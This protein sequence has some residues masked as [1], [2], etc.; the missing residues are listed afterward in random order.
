MSTPSPVA[1]DTTAPPARRSL[2]R[3]AVRPLRAALG[4]LTL[5][6]TLSLA[7]SAHAQSLE[8]CGT[9]NVRLPLGPTTADLYTAKEQI[10]LYL[11]SLQQSDFTFTNQTPPLFENPFDL[12]KMDPYETAPVNGMP[13]STWIPPSLPD[14]IPTLDLEEL[15]RFWMYQTENDD[16]GIYM[17]TI[18]PEQFTLS[19]MQD[20]TRCRAVAPGVGWSTMNFWLPSWQYPGNPY[21]TDPTSRDAL[22]RRG[23]AWLALQMIMI[24]WNA[25]GGYTAAPS[26]QV[27]S[28]F[29]LSQ[30]TFAHPLP[31][32]TPP[33]P[34]DSGLNTGYELGGELSHMAFVYQ[35]VKDIIPDWVLP[36]YEAMLRMFAERVVFWGPTCTMANLATRGVH[37]LHLVWQLTNDADVWT[38]YDHLID[39]FYA[40][41]SGGFF[42]AGYFVD[43]GRFDSGYNETNLLQTVRLLQLDSNV[44]PEVVDVANR[45]FDLHAHLVFR[46]PGP[47]NWYSPNEFNTRA[48][49]AAVAGGTSRASHGGG[50]QRELPGVMAGLPWSHAFLRDAPILGPEWSDPYGPSLSPHQGDY[51]KELICRM[52]DKAYW[53]NHAIQNPPSWYAPLV[54]MDWPEGADRDYTQPQFATVQYQHSQLETW[55]DEVAGDPALALFPFE[56]QGPYLRSFDRELLYARFGGAPSD[57]GYVAL[58]HAGPVGSGFGTSAAGDRL[59][60]GFG[61]GQVATFWGPHTGAATRGMRFGHNNLTADSWSDWRTWPLHTVWLVGPSGLPTTAAAIANPNYDTTLSTQDFSTA[62]IAYAVSMEPCPNTIMQLFSFPLGMG[63]SVEDDAVAAVVRVCGDIP[64][65]L[66]HLSDLED[67]TL[68]DAVHYERAIYTGADGVWVQTTLAPTSNV[69]PITE[70]WETIP[71]FDLQQSWNNNWPYAPMTVRFTVWPGGDEYSAQTTLLQPG[72]LAMAPVAD[73]KKVY[74]ERAN[75]AYEIVFEDVQSVG[76]SAEWPTPDASVHARNLLIDRLGQGGLQTAPLRY[77]IVMLTDESGTTIPPPP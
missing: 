53:L 70:A 56:Q 7:P 68:G 69:G 74:V 61:G 37:G 51:H 66:R 75:G 29:P 3:A 30:P 48:G 46:D 27:P 60:L 76:L 59:P 41:Q 5:L 42:N 21:F 58:V 6:A 11:G 17:L 23:A 64:N 73:V 31:G 1:P 15:E 47:N 33:A 9:A 36:H 8:Q 20:T 34:G 67:T 63:T 49:S 50:I 55:R 12:Y 2:A 54:S 45:L 32:R 19:K 35:Q 28:G 38:L 43:T 44:R 57:R 13:C 72:T 14:T 39:V 24:D 18:P 22:K 4:A 10:W 71:L 77:Q 62:D 16:I 65:K 40:T 52:T 25:W 26:T